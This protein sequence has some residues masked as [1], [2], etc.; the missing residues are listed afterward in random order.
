MILIDSQEKTIPSVLG[1]LTNSFIVNNAFLKQIIIKPDTTTTT[2]DFEIVDV[3]GRS[4]YEETN[5]VGEF[6][7]LVDLPIYGN[8]TVNITNSS[9]DEDYLLLLTFRRS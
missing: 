6:N 4:V 3:N 1:E 7:Q 9:V 8:V 5:C 2:Y